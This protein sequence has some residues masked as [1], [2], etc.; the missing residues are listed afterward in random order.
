MIQTITSIILIITLP[1]IAVF[2]FVLIRRK[3]P[4]KT[5][6]PRLKVGDNGCAHRSNKDLNVT[7]MGDTDE[8]Y[9]CEICNKK[10]RGSELNGISR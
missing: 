6:V 3:Q 4:Q 5:K 10:V 2:L 7:A 9:L 8:Y 1:S